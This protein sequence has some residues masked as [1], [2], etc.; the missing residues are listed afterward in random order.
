MASL[1]AHFFSTLRRQLATL[2]RSFDHNRDD[3]TACKAPHGET[4]F[5]QIC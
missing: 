1:I 2:W 3:I 5:E 4:S